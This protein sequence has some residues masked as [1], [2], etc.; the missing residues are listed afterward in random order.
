MFVTQK[1]HKI[2]L[3]ILGLLSVLSLFPISGFAQVAGEPAFQKMKDL[4][5]QYAG[6]IGSFLIVPIG[7][8]ALIVNV[9]QL[10]WKLMTGETQGIGGK[11]GWILFTILLTAFGVWLGANAQ[12]IFA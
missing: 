7:V 4:I 1:S 6:L 11:L 3:S 9:V 5:F 2:Q 10:I 8:L 12:G